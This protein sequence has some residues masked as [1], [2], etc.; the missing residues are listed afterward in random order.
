[1]TKGQD[2]ARSRGGGRLVEPEV[3]LRNL[4]PAGWPSAVGHGQQGEQL[5]LRDTRGDVFTSNQVRTTRPSASRDAGH[6]ESAP[7]PDAP[8]H[9]RKSAAHDKAEV[10]AQRGV[11]DALPRADPPMLLTVAQVEAALQLG[12]TRTYELLRSGEIPVRR[13]GRLIRVSRLALEEWVAQS[14][15]PSRQS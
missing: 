4:G 7:G 8:G 14:A 15:E 13:V 3:G 5:L 2:H 1:M 9:V 12:R 6:D 11:G 10:N